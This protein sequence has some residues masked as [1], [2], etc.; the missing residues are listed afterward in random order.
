MFGVEDRERAGDPS[1]QGLQ[2]FP[3]QLRQRRVRE[4][5]CSTRVCGT[6]LYI[7]LEDGGGVGVAG[8]TRA[9]AW[10]FSGP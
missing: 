5:V 9:P 4:Y 10:Q 3:F 1:L 8:E 7:R 2:A 6:A